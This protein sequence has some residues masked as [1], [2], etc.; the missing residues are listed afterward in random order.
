MNESKP[1]NFLNLTEVG[2]KN[3]KGTGM[4]ENQ[5]SVWGARCKTLEQQKLDPQSIDT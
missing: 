5:N 2:E 4:P 3:I 1:H